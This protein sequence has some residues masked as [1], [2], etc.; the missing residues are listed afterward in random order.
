MT[1]PESISGSWV[2]IPTPMHEDGS[3]NYDEFRRLL[4]FQPAN[5]SSAVLICGSAGEVSMLDPEER[6]EVIR[7]IGRA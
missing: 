6:R 1:T 4:D 5:G 7:Q 3:V 2:A